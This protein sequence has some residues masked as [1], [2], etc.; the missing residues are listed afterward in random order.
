MF[1]KSM[2]ILVKILLYKV[3]VLYDEGKNIRDCEDWTWKD[4]DILNSSLFFT[5]KP[6]VYLVNV[7]EK[8]YISKKNKWLAK[9]VKWINSHGGGKIIPYSVAFEQAYQDATDKVAFV[10]EKGIDSAMSKIINAGYSCLDLMH[11]F[12]AGED[13]VKC[14]TF[15][16]GT[17]A[18]QAAGIIHTDFERGFISADVMKYDDL[19][20]YG[21]EN[22]VKKEGKIE[23]KGK[24]YEVL[25]GDIILFKFNVSDPKKKK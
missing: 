22:N 4:I 12:T 15:R 13:E 18:P 25:D 23:T 3:K 24:T 21:N 11:Y 7:S 2:Y 20:L 6:M 5:A 1:G 14:W 19:I 16:K 10:K 17:K 9:I 8:D